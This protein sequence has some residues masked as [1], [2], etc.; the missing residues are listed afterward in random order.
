MHVWRDIWP[1]LT[2]LLVLIAMAGVLLLT[3]VLTR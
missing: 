3:Y 2:V 1:E